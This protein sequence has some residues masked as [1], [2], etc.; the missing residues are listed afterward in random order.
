[1]PQLHEG[2]HT[3]QKQEEKQYRLGEAEDGVLETRS[4]PVAGRDARN[5]ERE[6]GEHGSG[7]RRGKH[8]RHA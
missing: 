4:R 7:L 5:R 2:A 3:V 8:R 1:M 6:D